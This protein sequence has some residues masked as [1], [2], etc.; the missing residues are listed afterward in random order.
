ML[1]IYQER[2][3]GNPGW[4]GGW[5]CNMVRNGAIEK[6]TWEQSPKMYVPCAGIHISSTSWLPAPAFIKQPHEKLMFTE[7]I[8]HAKHV[9]CRSSA[10]PRIP[11]ILVFNHKDANKKKGEL[12]SWI[13]AHSSYTVSKDTNPGISDSRTHTPYVVLLVWVFTWLADSCVPHTLSHSF[14]Y[15]PPNHSIHKISVVVYCL[16]VGNRA[17]I[18]QSSGKGKHWDLHTGPELWPQNARR[19]E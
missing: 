7:H 6:V 16:L 3:R 15:F 4:G 11:L 1:K 10:H 18:W 12:V 8:L 2:G 14:T 13:R 17:A 9:P 19:Q 5:D